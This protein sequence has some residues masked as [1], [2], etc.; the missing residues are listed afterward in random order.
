M[1][2][3]TTPK[4]QQPTADQIMSMDDRPTFPVEVPEWGLVGELAAVCRQPDVATLAAI[5][6]SCADDHKGKCLRA[7]KIIVEGCIS[8]KFGLQ[9]I[10]ALASAKSPTAIG[11]LVVAILAGGKKN[12]LLT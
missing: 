10:P 1:D 9:H 8:P 11:R 7:A 12:I 3:P 2:E 6:A 5:E 4:P